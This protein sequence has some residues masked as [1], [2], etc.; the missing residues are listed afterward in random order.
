[1]KEE[2]FEKL[3]R[4]KRIVGQNET[5]DGRIR[6]THCIVDLKE[7]RKVA[8]RLKLSHLIHQVHKTIHHWA[9]QQPDSAHLATARDVYADTGLCIGTMYCPNGMMT[10]FAL[11]FAFN[12]TVSWDE[13]NAAMIDAAE[14][15]AP[16]IVKRILN[17]T[18]CA[19]CGWRAPENLKDGEMCI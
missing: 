17:A 10:D 15:I 3:T 4:L 12:A 14:G 19:C 18:E 1:M 8:K 11:L 13:A 6:L 2:S 7:I 9:D 16:L 5:T